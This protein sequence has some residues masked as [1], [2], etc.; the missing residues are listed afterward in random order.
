MNTITPG[1]CSG[2]NIPRIPL[3]VGVVLA[4]EFGRGWGRVRRKEKGEERR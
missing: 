4:V 1:A 2:G 3:K